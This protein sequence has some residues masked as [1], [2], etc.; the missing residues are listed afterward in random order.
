MKLC[1]ASFL[2]M[3]P[4]LL[5][6]SVTG[7]DWVENSD[8]LPGEYLDFCGIIEA[9]THQVKFQRFLVY[10]SSIPDLAWESHFSSDSSFSL[11]LTET[12]ILSEQPSVRFLRI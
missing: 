1:I 4:L 6:I 2:F 7:A 5:F 12:L 9:E 3:L 8:I 11:E 10:L